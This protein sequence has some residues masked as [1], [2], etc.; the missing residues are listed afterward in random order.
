MQDALKVDFTEAADG[1]KIISRTEV[2][3]LASQG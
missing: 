1:R 2:Y 3:T